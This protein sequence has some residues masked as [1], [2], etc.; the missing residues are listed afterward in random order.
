[1]VCVCTL[2]EGVGSEVRPGSALV[3][4]P[5]A[6]EEVDEN[7]ETAVFY[8]FDPSPVTGS[9][10]PGGKVQ[11]KSAWVLKILQFFSKSLARKD[12]EITF[13]AIK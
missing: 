9:R 2:I 3:D 8:F 12:V 13:E 7:H 11:L 4:S 1:M 10:P 6:R 5:T